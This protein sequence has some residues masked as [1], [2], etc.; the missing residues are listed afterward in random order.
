MLCVFLVKP[1]KNRNTLFMLLVIFHLIYAKGLSVDPVTENNII[2]NPN[3]GRWLLCCW[4]EDRTGGDHGAGSSEGERVPAKCGCPWWLGKPQ[5]TCHG[6]Y[7]GRGPSTAVHQHQLCHYH[8]GEYPWRTAVSFVYG[9]F[10]L[11][12]SSLPDVLCD[13]SVFRN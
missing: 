9:T 13:W 5:R 10:F 6:I 11:F 1:S 7:S 4:Q 2:D 8:T 3:R 12:M